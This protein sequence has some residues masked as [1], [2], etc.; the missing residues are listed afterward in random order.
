MGGV[1]ARLASRRTSASWPA[2]A[3]SADA[4]SLPASRREADECLALHAARPELPPVAYDESWDRIVLRRLRAVT[5]A[6]RVPDAVRSPSSDDTTDATAPTTCRPCG[7]GSPRT[8]TS[9]PPPRPRRP[10][11]HRA[12]PA[13]ADG[14]GHPPRH[15]S[16]RPTPRHDRRAGR[17]GRRLESVGRRADRRR[18]RSRQRRPTEPADEP[19]RQPGQRRE[20]H[21]GARRL[22]HDHEQRPWP[23]RPSPP[24]RGSA[25]LVGPLAR[26]PRTRT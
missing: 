8:A 4:P 15:G 21:R 6:G 13:P 25:S 17:D 10:P 9:V 22:G 14:R 12:L 23:S 3:A 5:A 2:S 18:R 1:G 16:P 7:P 26:H 24:R 11:E 20:E 19:D